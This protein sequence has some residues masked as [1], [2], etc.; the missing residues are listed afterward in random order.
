M[1]WLALIGPVLGIAG[2]AA[3]FL[4]SI[5]RESHFWTSSPTF[6]L[7]RCGVLIASIPMAYA[8]RSVVTGRSRLEEFGIASLFV[9][10][11]HVEMVYGFLTWPIH[12]SLTFEQA[13]VAFVLFTVML[14]GLVRLKDRVV[15]GRQQAAAGAFQ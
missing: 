4:P 9:Y 15:T 8:W 14:Y 3:S 7:L 2:Y 12:R 6:F 13:M 5:Y 11:I 10:W 1:V